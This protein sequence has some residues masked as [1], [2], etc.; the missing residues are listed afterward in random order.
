MTLKTKLGCSFSIIYTR[1]NV[2]SHSLGCYLILKKVSIHYL[3]VEVQNQSHKIKFYYSLKNPKTLLKL[4][5][6]S[7]QNL[8]ITTTINFQGKLKMKEE[9]KKYI[10]ISKSCFS[11]M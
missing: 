4:F 3:D 5:G 1:T 7:V 11:S 10:Y 8:L 2:F 9:E 6:S